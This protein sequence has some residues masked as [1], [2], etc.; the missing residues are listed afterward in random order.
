LGLGPENGKEKTSYVQRRIREI[1]FMC[2]LLRTSP[3]DEQIQEMAIEMNAL[4]SEFEDLYPQMGV[5]G[6]ASYVTKYKQAKKEGDTFFVNAYERLQGLES[7]MIKIVGEGEASEIKSATAVFADLL[8]EMPKNHVI[9]KL[10]QGDEMAQMEMLVLTMRYYHDAIDQV[11]SLPP[12]V[13]ALKIAQFEKSILFYKH[14]LDGKLRKK[15]IANLGEEAQKMKEGGKQ[16]KLR[17][18]I[19]KVKDY[20]QDK[21]NSAL[22][23][24]LG[25][26]DESVIVWMHEKAFEL[27][28]SLSRPIKPN[29]PEVLKALEEELVGYLDS[30][31]EVVDESALDEAL[32]ACETIR[33]LPSR[34]VSFSEGKVFKA[35][36]G[37]FLNNVVF[38]TQEK[39]I[40]VHAETMSTAYRYSHG[41]DS[42][43]TSDSLIRGKVAQMKGQ[44]V[45]RT[46][47]ILSPFG[48]LLPDNVEMKPYEERFAEFDK[49]MT[50]KGGE[51]CHMLW[52]NE[53]EVFPEMVKGWKTFTKEQKHYYFKTKKR[54]GLDNIQIQS[55]W[56][57]GFW[58]EHEILSMATQGGISYLTV[59]GGVPLAYHTIKKLGLIAGKKIPFLTKKVTKMPKKTPPALGKVGRI[60]WQAWLGYEIG[61]FINGEF[62]EGMDE[63]FQ[64]DIKDYLD[65]WGPGD[66]WPQAQAQDVRLRILR[67]ALM[68]KRGYF[69]SPGYDLTKLG[70][71][72]GYRHWLGFGDGD[73]WSLP[74]S[75]VE[76][77][78]FKESLM[79]A[80]FM[81]N[82]LGLSSF[83]VEI[84]L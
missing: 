9:D 71:T 2:D 19:G 29:D 74:D 37:K 13:R 1:E 62:L 41:I 28:R 73:G 57:T 7:K 26:S 20:A 52:R 15:W 67:S 23:V 80:N 68:H 33:A 59:K 12:Q 30:I 11:L 55:Y 60:A 58:E 72:F 14:L 42:M 84:D 36:M 38:P 54:G 49:S 3:H 47:Q 8:K 77:G 46:L 32:A 6:S 39:I 56:D 17:E 35:A 48:I 78:E 10:F 53:G 25:G 31:G 65:K 16:D 18:T 66:K 50:E 79:E 5:F 83:T 61:D 43:M 69:Q 70:M 51:E 63:S 81:L 27:E 40:S 45:W 64:E 44:D 22:A 24:L 75:M 82:I 34:K 76:T 4:Y 21:M